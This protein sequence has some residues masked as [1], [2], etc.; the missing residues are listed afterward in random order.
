MS[1]IDHV[2]AAC[3]M[4][5]VMPG[6][7]EAGSNAATLAHHLIMALGELE[8]ERLDR[9]LFSDVVDAL[10]RHLPGDTIPVELIKRLERICTRA[11]P[12]DEPEVVDEFVITLHNEPD[13]PDLGWHP[14]LGF[15]EI[16][17]AAVFTVH[18][19]EGCRVPAGGVVCKLKPSD[20]GHE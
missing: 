1:A 20:D 3:R 13:G 11:P 18:E 15:V 12:L 17:K 6:A 19:I 2:R 10:A 14:E 7:K 8:H 4:A 16:E 9:S 5:Q